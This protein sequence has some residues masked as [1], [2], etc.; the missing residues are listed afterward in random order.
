MAETV[1]KTAAPRRRTGSAAKAAASK[2]AA[3]KQPSATTAES[4][5]TTIGP[6]ELIADGETKNYS[7]WD[8]P[9]GIKAKVCVGKVYGPLGCTRMTVM[10]YGPAEE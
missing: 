7:R 6:I 4:G 10:V 1:T 8:W 2:P 5:E 9:E 3:S